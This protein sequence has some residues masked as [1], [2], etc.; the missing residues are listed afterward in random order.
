MATEYIRIVRETLET[1]CQQVFQRLGLSEEDA[2]IA[3]A[4]LVAAV[5][6]DSMV[7]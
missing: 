4:V 2:R 1:F 3:A 7:R 5:I 6:L